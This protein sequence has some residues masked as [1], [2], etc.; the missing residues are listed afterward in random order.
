MT[1]IYETTYEIF[2]VR[3]IFNICLIIAL[4]IFAGYLLSKMREKEPKS[5]QRNIYM[6]YILFLISYALTRV[7]FIFSDFEV[8]NTMSSETALNNIYVGIAY[9]FGIFGALCLIFMI[10]RY[11]IHNLSFLLPCWL[12]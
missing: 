5:A 8:Y 7:I 9:S 6:G 1:E 4:I 3:E 2:L 11:L 10:E 12:V